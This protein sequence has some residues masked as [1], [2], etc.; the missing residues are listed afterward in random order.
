[1]KRIVM[2]MVL[3]MMA[4]TAFA[5]VSLD[6]VWTDLTFRGGN[7]NEAQS[8][9]FNRNR[10]IAGEVFT[11]AAD[12]QVSV[13]GYNANTGTLVWEDTIPDGG[14]VHV[15]A[16]GN[17]AFAAVGFA[18]SP[19]VPNLLIRSYAQRTGDIQ[20]S[21][22]LELD[23]LTAFGVRGNRVLLS[24]R[25]ASAGV[26]GSKGFIFVLDRAT[27]HLLQTTILEG[28]V[29]VPITESVFWD[30]DRSGTDLV[31][32]GTQSRAGEGKLILRDYR[33]S[34]GQLKW[35][36]IVPSSPTETTIQL[37]NGLIYV[38]DQFAMAAYTLRNGAL[39]WQVTHLGTD[40]PVFAVTDTAV[41]LSFRIDNL[42]GNYAVER[43]NPFTGALVW[44]TLIP[45]ISMRDQTIGGIGIVHGYLVLVGS[46]RS[47]SGGPSVDQE[48]IV[49]VLDEHGTLLL[50]DKSDERPQAHFNDHAVSGNR[51]VGVG[52]FS[53][54]LGGAFVR[55]YQLLTG[56][57]P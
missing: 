47:P 10:V 46:T 5:Q 22:M 33:V 41:F 9:A 12:S 31:V 25:S 8:V 49:R 15:D 13:R 6:V 29:G 30:F 28:P 35:E 57:Q 42:Q 21:T 2:I 56:I 27:G 20:W 16:A 3:L 53:E 39:A 23:F 26:V 4:S 40:A 43:R 34:D 17:D 32:A 11:F 18:V 37:A 7:A 19:P 36:T 1:M 44:R 55:M 54:P 45:A 38:S 50:E 14:A 52:S 48:L 51:I 24:G